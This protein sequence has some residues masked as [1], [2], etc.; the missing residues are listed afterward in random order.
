[1][2]EN[3]SVVDQLTAIDF[4]AFL[5]RVFQTV[6]PG[7]EF[8]ANW[9]HDAVSW[10]L[11]EIEQGLNRRLIIN[12][13]PRSLKSII[14]SVA[15]P[16]WLLGHNPTMQIVC[17][18]YS[19]GLAA[20]LA[21]QCRRVMESAWYRRI[22]P[23][24]RLS[25]RTA[26]H[27][28]ET[29][30]GGGRFSTSIDGTVTGRGGGLIIID[31]P[32]NAS[33]ACSEAVR[34]RVI[35]FFR[36]TG[37]SRLDD[38][39]NGG[40]VLVM[41]RLHEEDLSGHLLSQDGWKHLCLPARATEDQQIA[42]GPDEIH[43][44]ERGSILQPDRESEETLAEIEREMGSAAFS[45]QYQQEPIPASGVMV[46]REWLKYY[47][48]LPELG[49]GGQIVQSWDTASKDGVLNDYSCCVTALVRKKKVY[50]LDLFREKLDFPS[51]KAN[52]V[53]LARLW[54]ARVL[55]IEDAASGS[56]LLQVLRFEEPPGVPSPIRRTPTGDKISRFSGQ[57]ARI[58]GG[59]LILPRE[60]PW[61]A[62]LLH[63]LLGFPHA[64]YDDQVDSLTH[65][66][67]WMATRVEPVSNCGPVLVVAG[68]PS[69]WPFGEYDPDEPVIEDP[70]SG[71]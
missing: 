35:E 6:S 14:V 21:R 71:C 19:G 47:D 55:L 42:I 25:K 40:I 23:R 22:F 26:E 65:L 12:I 57:T 24:A 54:N 28:Y 53:R 43:F 67:G 36:G 63:E 17:I 30:S 46:K 41:Q 1:M 8:S 18:S 4:A 3:L 48:S 2:R 51:L 29:V 59:D 37:M 34:Q 58:E 61:L 39:K 60:A 69:S 9:H 11:T 62:S 5:M 33:D 64:K 66:L 56:Q 10:A 31:D 68:E 70:W 7:D 27:D 15:W 44:R 45:A 32:M 49:D 38:K 13:P 20:K 50:V 52:V 16:A